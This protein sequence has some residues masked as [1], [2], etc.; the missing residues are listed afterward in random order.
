MICNYSQLVII[1]SK[2]SNVPFYGHHQSFNN[3]SSTY[4]VTQDN[5]QVPEVNNNLHKRVATILASLSCDT[6]LSCVLVLLLQVIVMTMC[7]RCVLGG[8]CSQSS[9]PIARLRWGSQLIRNP[10]LPDWQC[11][12]GLQEPCSPCYIPLQVYVHTAGFL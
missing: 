5:S 11:M 6:Q 7:R 10:T 2:S 4:V 1:K 8:A 3:D 9:Y 12:R